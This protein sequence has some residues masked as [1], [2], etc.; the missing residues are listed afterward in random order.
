[1]KCKVD[2]STAVLLRLYT[3]LRQDFVGRSN[4]KL[5]VQT[6]V[7]CLFQSIQLLFHVSVPCFA[8]NSY[9][10]PTKI[11]LNSLSISPEKVHHGQSIYA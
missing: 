6:L 9:H 11:S 2:T 3:S 4:L 1:M 7:R 5:N 10:H 8:V